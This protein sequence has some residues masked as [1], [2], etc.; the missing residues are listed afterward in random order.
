MKKAASANK[1]DK[2]LIFQQVGD[3]LIIF[4]SERSE[5]LTLNE[6]A[7]RIFK[8]LKKGDL[9]EKIADKI[10]KTYTIPKTKALHDVRDI[11]TQM[12]KLKIIA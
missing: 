8:L 1:K 10:V 7:T 12:K 4:D 5:L 9:E 2:G 3:E 11:S 6:T